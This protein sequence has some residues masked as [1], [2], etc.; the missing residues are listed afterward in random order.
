MGI[1]F[2]FTRGNKGKI[3]NAGDLLDTMLMATLLCDAVI[4]KLREEKGMGEEQAMNFLLKSI[5]IGYKG[6]R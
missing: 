4:H 5:R 6:L 3:I 1:S 2:I